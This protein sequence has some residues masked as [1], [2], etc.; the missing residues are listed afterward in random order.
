MHRGAVESFPVTQSAA[1]VIVPSQV[2]LAVHAELAETGT[3]T[4]V[5][6]ELTCPGAF[7]E[8]TGKLLPGVICVLG[9]SAIADVASGT[10]ASNTLESRP[11]M[12][13][14]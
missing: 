11:T 13:P 6:G 9:M 5:Q 3:P 7:D 8:L 2:R 12:K 14:S 1:I 10:D 4:P